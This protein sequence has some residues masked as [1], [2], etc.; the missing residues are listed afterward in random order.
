MIFP[1]AYIERIKPKTIFEFGSFDGK[2]AIE[3]T[4]A[5]PFARVISFEADP[6]RF[7]ICERNLYGSGIEI[8]HAAITNFTY[9]ETSKLGLQ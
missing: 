7:E 1:Y 5:F 9:E 2:D 4:K 3:L 8:H 6:E